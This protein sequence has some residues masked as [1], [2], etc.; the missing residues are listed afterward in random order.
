MEITQDHVDPGV[1]ADLTAISN[2]DNSWYAIYNPWNSTP[3]ALA[4]AAWAE[5]AKKLFLLDTQETDCATV[6]SGSDSTSVMAQVKTAAYEYSPT[7]Y[8][9]SNGSFIGAAWL[10]RC[11][12]FEPGSETWA[13]KTLAGVAAVKLT[14]THITN[15]KAKNGNYYI[16]IAEKNVTLNGVT[17]GTRKYIDVLR[18]IDWAQAD[19]GIEVFNAL[20]AV[21]KVPF[22]QQG[23]SIVEGKMYRSLSKGV[24]V[25][26]WAPTP[27]PKVF[28]PKVEDI[29]AADKNNRLL[30]DLFFDATL[31]GAVHGVKIRGRVSV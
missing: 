9:T 2:E 25:R 24:R 15:L 20:T 14:D 18:F 7:V 10:G 8:H 17:S 1:A 12:P 27:P 30:P 22:T 28:V 4:I 23:V 6:T 21:A 19:M 11:L 29:A 3:M 5:T 13:L 26:G 16:T 31:G